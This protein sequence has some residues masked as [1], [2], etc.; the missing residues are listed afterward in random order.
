MDDEARELD[1]LVER[2]QTGYG[3]VRSLYESVREGMHQNAR[4]GIQRVI[5][6][7]P[8]EHRVS[9]VVYT[10]FVELLRGD[11]AA[12]TSPVGLAKT[13]AYRRGIDE[14]RRILRERQRIS[15][16][17]PLDIATTMPDKAGILA[18]AEEEALHQLVAKCL[19]FLTTDQRAVVRATVMGNQTLSDWALTAGT[20]HQA[21]SRQRSRAL[22][23]LRRCVKR[24]RTAAGGK[25]TSHGRG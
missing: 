16:V 11:P 21:V 12:M 5:A 15:S 20:S 22:D 4:R 10:A 3:D 7:P 25:G 9:D 13:I 24:Q 23:A 8:D 19:E 2:W 18:A 17:D 6:R 14:G 1:E